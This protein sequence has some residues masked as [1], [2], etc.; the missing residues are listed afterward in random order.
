MHRSNEDRDVDLISTD[1]PSSDSR[2]AEVSCHTWNS[3]PVAYVHPCVCSGW[4]ETRNCDDIPDTEMDDQT[5]AYYFL[6]SP[7]GPLS[8]VPE[9][10]L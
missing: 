4:N 2:A 7:V 5:K 9:C 6:S 10:M 1:N 8:T 3:A